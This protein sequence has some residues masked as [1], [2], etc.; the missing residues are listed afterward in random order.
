[1]TF[2]MAS[3]QTTI[4]NIYTVMYYLTI[5]KD[6]M[7]RARKEVRDLKKKAGSDN[8]EEILEYE[9][10]PDLEFLQNCSNEALR[11]DPPVFNSLSLQLSGDAHIDNICFKKGTIF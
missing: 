7:E 1:M 6:L 5:K 3:T 8:W 10:L 2:L 4:I 9:N 11:I